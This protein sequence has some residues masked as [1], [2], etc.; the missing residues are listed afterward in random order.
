MEKIK[1]RFTY[2]KT[3]GKYYCE[4]TAEFEAGLFTNCIYPR[5]YVK[6]L[7]DTKQLPGVETGV[8]LGITLIEILS[9]EKYPELFIPGIK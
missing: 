7:W 1:I 9:P 3:T 4:G 2:F 5:D 6:V 8:W